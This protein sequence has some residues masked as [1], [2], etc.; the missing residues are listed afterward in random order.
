MTPA[1]AW[2][3]NVNICGLT[4]T[5]ANSYTDL[6]STD[7][8]TAQSGMPSTGGGDTWATGSTIAAREASVGLDPATGICSGCGGAGVDISELYQTMKVV[9]RNFG[10]QREHE[11]EHL[12]IRHQTHGLVM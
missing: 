6:N 3:G 11:R 4:Q 5:G 2:S 9:N 7:C 12:T 8:T 1:L 10:K